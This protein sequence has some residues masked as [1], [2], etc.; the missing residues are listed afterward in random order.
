MLQDSYKQKGRRKQLVEHLKRSGIQSEKVLKAI[1]HVPRHFFFPTDFEE[2]AY[3]DKPFPI[4]GG[5]TIS[6]P[7]TVARQTE[8]LDVKKGDK[9]LEVGTGSGYQAAILKVLGAEVYTIETVRELH[10]SSK[11]LFKKI[12]LQ[13]NTFYGD[14]SQGLKEFAPYDKI[15]LTAA[16]PNISKTLTEQ[17]K[18]G[19]KLLAPVGSLD[20]Q[21]MILVKR[22]G[23][24][25]F[26][27]S[28]HGTFTFVP[29][30]GIYGWND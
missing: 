7:F 4:E 15:I 18:I 17:L 28:T 2:K 25:E 5:Q 3:D 9:I 30:T 16:A 20:V 19:G 14:G 12:G 8:L 23:E 6:Q 22:V 11:A 10:D 24:N 1:M 13:I 29:L 27:K 21:K 26:E